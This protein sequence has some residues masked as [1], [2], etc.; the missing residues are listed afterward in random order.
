[1]APYAISGSAGV[2]T[3][4]V[5]MLAR[6]PARCSPTTAWSRS[7]TTPAHALHHAVVSEHCA[8]VAWATRAFGGHFPLPAS[9][10]EKFAEAYRRRR[11]R[12]G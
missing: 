5:W 11:H 3:N 1:V 9:T 8:Q 7:R 10:L 12:L 6:G 4:A 2:G